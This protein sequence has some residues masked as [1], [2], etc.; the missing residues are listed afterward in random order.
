M[1]LKIKYFNILSRPTY[2][3][4]QSWLKKI[5]AQFCCNSL[6]K[7]RLFRVKSLFC[8][9]E[10]TGRLLCQ[11]WFLI[12]CHPT[13]SKLYVLWPEQHSGPAEALVHT[14]QR[15]GHHCD[16]RYLFPGLPLFPLFLIFTTCISSNNEQKRI[17]YDGKQ[18]HDSN[19]N[20]KNYGEKLALCGYKREKMT[21]FLSY[22]RTTLSHL[23]FAPSVLHV[24]H[25]SLLSPILI[26]YWDSKVSAIQG[27][28][29][30]L[31]LILL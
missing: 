8:D 18:Q 24:G 19:I 14:A 30:Y 31:C 2:F 21:M 5:R 20:V 10:Q 23:P 13:S 25:F 22:P 12:S 3:A 9:P 6:K 1:N 15:S 4:P 29:I 28:S 7:K 27:T 26:L 11:T 16:P 17:T